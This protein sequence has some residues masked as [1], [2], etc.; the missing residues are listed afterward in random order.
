MVLGM[1]YM[2]GDD[3]AYVF[4]KEGYLTIFK[5]ISTGSLTEFLYL[6]DLIADE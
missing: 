3:C 6:V 5:G 1:N 2:L 4:D